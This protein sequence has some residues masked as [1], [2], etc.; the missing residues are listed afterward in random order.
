MIPRVFALLGRPS[1]QGLEA[2]ALPTIAFA[3]VTALLG[4]VLGGAQSFWGYRDE[5]AGLYQGFAVIALVL[6]TVPLVSLGAAAARLSARRRDDRLATLRLLGASAGST[7]LLAILEAAVVAFAGAI[8][9]AL[10]ALAATPLVGLIHFRGGPLGTAAV[11]LPWWGYT[12]IVAGITLIATASAAASLRRVIISPLGVALKQSAPRIPWIP[13]LIAVVAIALSGGIMGNLGGLGGAA[14]II[15]G[16]GVALT[17]TLFAIDVIGAW[18]VGV[19]ARR[20]AKRAGRPDQLLAARA[21]LESPRAAWRQVSGVAMSSFMAVFAGSGVAMLGVMESGDQLSGA[22]AFLVGDIRTGLI[23]TI[24]GT[25][26]MVACAVGVSQAAQIL[27]RRDIHRSLDVIGTPI[28]TRD[29]ARRGAT[30]L[31]LLLASLGSAAIAAFLLFPVVGGALIL[32]P[33]SLGV[34]L[35]TLAAGIGIVVLALVATRPLLRA[36]ARAA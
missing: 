11:A 20:Q 18:F 6:L 16:V 25:F 36:S 10:I 12:A 5:L 27:D 24:I 2:I 33:L 7:A 23:I 3:C 13:A 15:A 17:V 1:R 30:M 8:A 26:I 29:R 14:A 21:V 9:G 34:I 35:A 28:E 31:P 32:A 4:I 19:L 22:E